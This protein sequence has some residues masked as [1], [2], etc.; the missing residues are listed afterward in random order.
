MLLSRAVVLRMMPGELLKSGRKG[1]LGKQES[2]SVPN[3]VRSLL[4]SD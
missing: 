2:L 1:F 3:S 4:T